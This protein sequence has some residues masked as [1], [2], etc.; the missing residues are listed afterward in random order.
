MLFDNPTINTILVILLFV[1]IWVYVLKLNT[2]ATKTLVQ[3]VARQQ[4][5]I[6]QSDEVRLLCRA[7]HYLHPTIHAGID[8]I[9]KEGGP[10]QG[11]F[12]EEWFHSNIPQPKP[13]ELEQALNTISD[14]D[15]AKDHA[16]Q[17]LKEYPSVGDQLDAAYKARR[18]DHS[19]QIRLDTLISQ[20]KEKY[21]KSDEN[22]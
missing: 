20:V 9:V 5:N 17:R 14:I 4:S 7:I 2:H 8:Y 18:G 1:C 3:Q 15:P 12:I 16:A 13:E 6:R 21:P 10:G 11:A 19:E 22:L